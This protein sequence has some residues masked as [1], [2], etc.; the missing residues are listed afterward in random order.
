MLL[1]CDRDFFYA[2]FFFILEVDSKLLISVFQCG[3]E[4]FHF[5]NSK[6]MRKLILTKTARQINSS[7]LFCK[8]HDIL[9]VTWNILKIAHDKTL[10]AIS[11]KS[12]LSE[13]QLRYQVTGSTKKYVIKVVMLQATAK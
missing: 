12:N 10:V 6:G 3:I 8:D 2:F 4:K 7:E 9:A 11:M 5:Q 13:V 1:I